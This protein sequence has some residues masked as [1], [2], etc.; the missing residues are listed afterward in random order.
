MN[1]LLSE[2]EVIANDAEGNCLFESVAYLINKLPRDDDDEDISHHDVRRMVYD[3]YKEFDRD[4]KYPTI[5]IESAI[6]LGLSFDNEDD[7]ENEDG[8]LMKH[9]DNVEYDKVWGSVTDLLVCSVIFDV[10]ID[11][12]KKYDD[13]CYMD[14]ISFQYENKHTIGIL[15]NGINHFEAIEKNIFCD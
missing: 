9:E 10:D 7:D 15:Y 8:E 4:I 14:K 12:F 6:L 2:Y 11:L 5:A 1:N 13:K 3:F